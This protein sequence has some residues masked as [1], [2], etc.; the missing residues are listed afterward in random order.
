MWIYIFMLNKSEDTHENKALMKMVILKQ[1]SEKS[2]GVCTWKRP[3][4]KCAL[5]LTIMGCA[6]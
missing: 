3:G 4:S 2:P 6:F 5:Y 1:K